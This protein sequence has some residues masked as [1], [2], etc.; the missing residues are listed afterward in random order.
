MSGQS[1]LLMICSGVLA[2]PSGSIQGS[3][4]GDC[5]WEISK[6]GWIRGGF[7]S[8]GQPKWVDGSWAFALAQP[9]SVPG[10]IC[11]AVVSYGLLTTRRLLQKVFATTLERLP[12]GRCYALWQYCLVW[13]TPN[14]RCLIY[15]ECDKALRVER[16][17]EK[18]KVLS[19]RNKITL[20]ERIWGQVVSWLPLP[21]GLGQHLDS[22]WGRYELAVT[23]SCGWGG[24]TACWLA[25]T[26]LPFPLPVLPS[27]RLRRRNSSLVQWDR[28]LCGSC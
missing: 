25:I 20:E 4:A 22:V 17:N 3:E 1:L 18:W 10:S 16:S 14:P 8:G 27:A 15:V 11:K 24:R 26:A 2:F 5:L 7:S 9:E 13:C 23:S 19:D 28:F 21:W 6:P 12:T